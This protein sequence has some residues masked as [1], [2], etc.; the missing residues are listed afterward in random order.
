MVSALSNCCQSLC[1]RHT[2][3]QRTPWHADRR[4]ARGWQSQT[5]GG[6]IQG[7]GW[8]LRRS[9]HAEFSLPRG[10]GGR[11]PGPLPVFIQLTFMPKLVLWYFL[12]SRKYRPPL[13]PR[14]LLHSRIIHPIAGK[15][16]SRDWRFLYPIM[17]FRQA[18]SARSCQR[19]PSRY[20]G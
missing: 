3:T 18:G 4:S 12:D 8:R 7:D 17:R 10:R 16:Q 15:R 9:G 20:R 2:P 13:V 19:N 11:W 6:N 5:Q 14:P 1:K